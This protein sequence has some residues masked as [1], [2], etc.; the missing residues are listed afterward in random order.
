[1]INGYLR[2]CLPLNNASGSV[3]VI[4]LGG[5]GGG[6]L[7]AVIRSIG[8]A[9]VLGLIRGFAIGTEPDRIIF[10]GFRSND[11]SSLSKLFD[12]H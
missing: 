9:E 12:W 4:V 7:F 6:G 3:I 8:I 1:M 11:D 10:N 5:N 2:T